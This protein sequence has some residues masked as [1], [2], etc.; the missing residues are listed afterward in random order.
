M[1]LV[2]INQELIQQGD[3]IELL[4]GLFETF[5]IISY[6][7]PHIATYRILGKGVP[8]NDTY[9][10]LLFSVTINKEGRQ[11]HFDGWNP[12]NSEPIS[13]RLLFQ[14]RPPSQPCP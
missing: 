7:T 9:V 4:Q 11:V 6:D 12:Y 8:S 1:A 3:V 2:K 5:E 10:E 14:R 13:A